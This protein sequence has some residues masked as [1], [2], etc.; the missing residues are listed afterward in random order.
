MNIAQW[1]PIETA[2]KSK[3]ILL[4]YKNSCGM[5]RIIIGYYIKKYSEEIDLDYDEDFAD[6]CEESDTYFYKE[7]WFEWIWNHPDFCFLSIEDDEAPTHWL[8]LPKNPEED[9]K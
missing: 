7:G 6:Y 4:F 5:S 3:K 1:Q 9:S 8:P 2:P